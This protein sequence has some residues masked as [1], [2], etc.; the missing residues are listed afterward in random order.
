[1]PE[2]AG[3]WSSLATRIAGWHGE[4][5]SPDEI[6]RRARSQTR[7][8]AAL[9]RHGDAIEM[10][11]HAGLGEPVRRLDDTPRTLAQAADAAAVIA[12]RVASWSDARAR[13]R[14]AAA[15]RG[16]LAAR[17]RTKREHTQWWVYA[18]VGAA[19]V[20]GAIVVGV[21]HYESDTQT[22]EL[23]LPMRRWP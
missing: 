20:A 9:V 8:R 22:V 15:R 23:A 1:M 18:A 6:A 4:L 7:M 16:S 11:G 3:R 19:L 14:S 13:L 10:W 12:E 17:Q 21:H 2:Q 5:P